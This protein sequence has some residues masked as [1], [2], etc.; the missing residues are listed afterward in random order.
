MFSIKAAEDTIAFSFPTPEGKSTPVD[1]TE[2]R[3]VP[4]HI[5]LL[6]PIADYITRLKPRSHVNYARATVVLGRAL[7]GMELRSL[8]STDMDWQ[9]LLLGVQEVVL[10]DATSKATLETRA[11][12]TMPI[13]ETLFRHLRNE[14]LIPHGVVIP[15]SAAVY[16]EMTGTSEKARLLGQAHIRAGSFSK[17]KILVAIDLARSDAEYL[18][19][20]RLTL[21]EKVHA[22]RR[23]LERYFRALKAH[24]DWGRTH[25][26]DIDVSTIKTRVARGDYLTS[27]VLDGQG[28]DTKAKGNRWGQHICRPTS[29]AGL[30]N[31][32]AVCRESFDGLPTDR[33]SI[34]SDLIPA[35]SMDRPLPQIE[36]VH[37]PFTPNKDVVGDIS[38]NIV[39]RRL[40]WF[41]GRLHFDDIAVLSAIL[42][43][44]QPS[45]TPEAVTRAR[46][47]D[48]NGR[49]FLQCGD[50]GARFE[51]K[52]NR[53]HSTKKEVLSPLSQ[54]VINF[55][56]EIT[57]DDRTTL[58]QSKSPLAEL[59]FIAYDTWGRTAM[60]PRHEATVAFLS[61][62]QPS[63]LSLGDLFAELPEKG[64]G[65]G[66][67]SFSKIR[68]SAGVL[69]FL[70]T[71]SPSDVAR[72]LGNKT[73][74][75]LK[76]YIPL[77]L[78]D[79]WNTR[80]VRQFQN[81]WITVAAAGET[82]LTEVTDFDDANTLNRFLSNMLRSHTKTH[83]PLAA[84]LHSRFS[85]HDESKGVD[86]ENVARSSLQVS[87]SRKNLATLYCLSDALLDCGRPR[88]DLESG[89]LPGGI[90]PKDLVTL[91]Q[92]LRSQLP[93]SVNPEFKRVH[94][95]A[96][97]DSRSL[98]A[99]TSWNLVVS[100]AE[101]LW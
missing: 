100:K 4:N 81:L 49:S 2:W 70:R 3:H 58:R 27:K 67:I 52:K 47:F 13:I 74:T 57:E 6:Q 85:G 97:S 11:T 34:E 26:R 44:E 88:G 86:G 95:Q 99:G 14:G 66:C 101:S 9:Q 38:S 79:A 10:S 8:P 87:I 55:V 5:C 51:V 65:K 21:N 43:H 28:G 12:I 60:Y 7:A 42:I 15:D 53:A 89:E 50:S 61:G 92:L 36:G 54:E 45:F 80:M 72:K 83:S 82:F 35:W 63:R 90:I 46:L 20:L 41:F 68:A 56:L 48:K 75:T 31:F 23:V 91:T 30:A 98:R 59:L 1:A 32:L 29:E 77:A 16:R 78:L 18:D 62:S 84:E 24:W 64:L 40:R 76:Y 73:R 22:V 71:G 37:D 33:E 39:V 93:N 19:E 96:D 17:T 94:E 25:S 69:E